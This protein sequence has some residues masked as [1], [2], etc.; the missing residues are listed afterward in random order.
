M[1]WRS[2]SCKDFETNRTPIAAEEFL[3]DLKKTMDPLESGSRHSIPFLFVLFLLHS[4]VP[5]TDRNRLAV[6]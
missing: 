6:L 5:F 3:R 1:Y 4:L 2:S